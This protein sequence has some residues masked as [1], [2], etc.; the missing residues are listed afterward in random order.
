MNTKEL[1]NRLFFELRGKMSFDDLL[2]VVVACIFISHENRRVL[3]ELMQLSKD[4]LYN[5]FINKQQ[6][7]GIEL[8]ALDF[9]RKLSSLSNDVIFEIYKL[10]LNIDPKNDAELMIEMVSSDGSFLNSM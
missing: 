6:Q 2:K 5:H 10:L 4:E 7:L 8:D 9:S 3:S 1:L